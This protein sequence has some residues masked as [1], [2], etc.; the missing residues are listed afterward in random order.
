M[1]GNMEDTIQK[2]CEIFGIKKLRG[3]LRKSGPDRSIWFEN[4]FRLFI[5]CCK[6]FMCLY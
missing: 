1:A 2:G 4:R 3:C 6:A 5:V